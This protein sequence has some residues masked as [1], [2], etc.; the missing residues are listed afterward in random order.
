[1]TEAGELRAAI[2][3]LLGGDT[4][5]SSKTILS[6]MCGVKISSAFGPSVPHDSADFGRCHRLLMLFPEWRQRLPE[7]SFEYPIWRPLIESWDSLEAD[8]KAAKSGD[9]RHKLY[10]RIQALIKKGESI[11]V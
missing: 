1:M 8:Y 7:V 2:H 3:W 10:D 6:V 9:D 4:G 11:E 5:T